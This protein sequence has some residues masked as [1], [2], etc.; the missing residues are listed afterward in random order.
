MTAIPFDSPDYLPAVPFGGALIANQPSI[1]IPANT[2]QGFGPFFVGAAQS[3]LVISNQDGAEPVGWDIAWSSGFAGLR[4]VLAF[5]SWNKNTALTQWGVYPVIGPEFII[6]V[7]NLNPGPST[8]SFAVVGVGSDL[9]AGEL[10][11]PQPQIDSQALSVGAGATVT[12]TP[13]AHIPG[14]AKLWAQTAGA[15]GLRLQYWTG[16]AWDFFYISNTTAAAEI[17][18]EIVIPADDWRVQWTNGTAG[19]LIAY[20]VIMAGD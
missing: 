16:T 8:I 12:L 19:A 3:I 9:R 15:L 2:G 6:N 20:L 7:S 1:A 13:T 4:S 14:R 18:D 17:S 11:P 10:I 5:P